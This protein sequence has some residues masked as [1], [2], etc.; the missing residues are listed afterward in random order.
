MDVELQGHP[1]NYTCKYDP[2][3]NDG[4]CSNV[5]RPFPGT[6]S[7]LLPDYRYY[8]LFQ[9]SMTCCNGETSCEFDDDFSKRLDHSCSGEKTLDL[10]YRCVDG[11][12]S[13]EDLSYAP[14]LDSPP[15][16][17]ETV[18]NNV[19]WEA[20]EF[21]AL[22][23]KDCPSGFLGFMTLRCEK[24]GV[25]QASGPNMSD[26][27]E[28]TILNEIKQDIENGNK[29]AIDVAKE[30][31]TLLESE[32]DTETVSTETVTD[33]LS[34]T[35][36]LLV[37]QLTENKTASE[38]QEAAT[39]YAE[40]AIRVCELAF[41]LDDDAS[42]EESASA[43]V[44]EIVDEIAFIV[45]GELEENMTT[46]VETKTI[47]MTVGVIPPRRRELTYPRDGIFTIGE[48]SLATGMLPTSA[49][50]DDIGL[51]NQIAFTEY[52]QGITL[53][54]RPSLARVQN[55]TEVLN[56]SVLNSIVFGVSATQ[57][58]TS[59]TSFNSGNGEEEFKFILTHYNKN[60]TGNVT[61]AFWDTEDRTESP[62]GSWRSRGC[63]VI[64]SNRT[65]TQCACTHL[66]NF[67]ILLDVTG[68]HKKIADGHKTALE[69]LTLV[70]CT[71]SIVC[72]AM[73]IFAFSFFKSL[74]NTRTTI[75]RNLCIS[76][77]VAE[78]LFLVGVDRTE[79]E[80]H[81]FVLLSPYYHFIVPAF[82]IACSVIAGL[83]H[84]SFLC[85]F[86]WM[87]LEGIQLYIMLVHVF[88]T[89]SKIFPYYLGGYGIPALIVGVAAGATQGKGYGTPK[90]CWLTTDHGFIWSFA[91]PVALVIV[92]NVVF[93]VVSIRVA[94]SGRA[95]VSKDA[96][97]SQN[98]KVWIKGAVTLTFL[99]GSTWVIGFL[100]LA[101][102]TL[103]L[104]YAFTVLNSLQGF[105]IFVY[106]CL[107][108]ERV[109]KEMA[110]LLLRQKWLPGC[111]RVRLEPLAASS[112][113]TYSTQQS[114][115]ET[116]SRHTNIDTVPLAE[117]KDTV[118]PVV[119]VQDVDVDDGRP[120][121][122]LYDK[123]GI[124][125]SKA[126]TTLNYPEPDYN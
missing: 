45:A 15:I 54:A 6:V 9:L 23:S 114:H 88:S 49:F 58:N 116:K 47:T 8:V 79:N 3:Q 91:G 108:N 57:G 19:T 12:F 87:C 107:G 86:A 46:T 59:V 111:L 40:E 18:R 63:R 74:W 106:H 31:G 4:T 125:E 95:A 90:N 99:L 20:A 122:W 52:Q 32:D 35:N 123:S 112:S 83:M 7:Y 89:T 100:N 42:P 33:L 65:H 44:A 62:S 55:V 71:I 82:Q 97:S 13:F 38:R 66:T 37:R 104:A 53:G 21:N 22:V 28:D 92:V 1:F 70:G 64:S 61:C 51:K 73:C 72:L 78:L 121:S 29:M 124:S 101:E 69:V 113:T 68:V 60:I 93:L 110:K 109:N 67:A 102:A 94:Y 30:I 27:V 77:L 36:D 14:P 81:T 75:H 117:K 96:T 24:G 2:C 10:R 126:N 56:T 76:L 25:W 85:A 11:N 50:S 26:C 5:I 115:A 48:K 41:S 103:P 105:F 34:G 98:I 17:E 120:R 84:Y 43:D 118:H 80:V 119:Y 39:E 16:C